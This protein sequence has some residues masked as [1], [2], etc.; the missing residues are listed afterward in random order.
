VDGMSYQHALITGASSGIGL[1][2]AK[3]LA[4]SGT[5]VTL[6]ARRKDALD[7]AA[8]E[9]G[10]QPGQVRTTTLDV[11]RPETTV[12]TIRALDDEVGGFDLVI[13][14]AG[15]SH[16]TW[17]GALE[18]H[19]VAPVIATN[20][21]GAVATLTA[22]L[23]RM[24]ERDRGHLVGVSSLAQYRGLPASAAYSASKAFLSTF[25]EALRID[26]HS[27]GVSVTDVRPGFVRTPMTD[28]NEHRMPFIMEPGEA[29]DA[30]IDAINKRRPVVAFPWPFA[31][32]VRS[33]RLLPAAI[34]DRAITRIKVGG[35]HPD[36]GTASRNQALESE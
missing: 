22:V 29:A 30:I 4:A 13:A 6:A 24:V 9:I 23:P 1:A 3:R 34:Y 36:N 17:S 19:D 20:V 7:A 33:A 18:W 16:H 8:V 2:V 32:L 10:L 25:L 11:T 5:N 14:N 35:M 26:L 28:S 27:T 31:M 21:A 15:I 12:E